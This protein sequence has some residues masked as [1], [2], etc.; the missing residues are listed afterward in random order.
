MKANILAFGLIAVLNPLG[1]ISEPLNLPMCYMI[2]A[3]G[4]IINLDYLCNA[5]APKQAISISSSVTADDV[6]ALA[7]DQ[8][9]AAKT[10]FQADEADKILNICQND[11]KRVEALTNLKLK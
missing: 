8:R 5:N 6:C 9:L 11:R 1:A 7:A 10:Q 3:R 4:R 2:T